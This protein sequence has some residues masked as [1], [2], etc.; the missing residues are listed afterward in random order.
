MYKD[1]DESADFKVVSLMMVGRG[2]SLLLVFSKMS[3]G[4]VIK[5]S[6]V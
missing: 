4:L 6:F 2:M 1:E 5:R 3:Q